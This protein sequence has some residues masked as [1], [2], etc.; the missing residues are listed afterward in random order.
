MSLAN[1]NKID[2]VFLLYILAL[3]SFGLIILTSASTPLGYDKFNDGYFFI[4]GQILNG[5]L[6]GL[7]LLYIFS[8]INYNF[9][10]KSVWLLVGFT[11]LLL[12]LVFIPGVGLYLNGARSWISFGFINFQPSELAKLTMVVLAAF[13][14]SDSRRDLSD[15]KT[16]LLPVLSVLAPI[17][18][19]VLAQPDLGTLSILV[20]IVFGMLYL[21]KVPKIYLTVL[22]SLLV[23][24]FLSLIVIKSYRMERF[25]TFLHP[26]LDPQGVGYHINQATLA[27]GSGGWAGLGVGHSR[28]KYQYLPEV[29][30][31][32]VF[33]V[34]A[35]EVGFL[36]SSL[37]LLLI[38]FIGW[39]GLRIAKKSPDLFAKLLVS[40]IMIWLVWQSFL[41]IGAMVGILPLTGVP[42]PFVSHGG[43]ALM[44]ML[45]A[46]GIVLSV[47]R[48]VNLK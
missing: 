36:F 42:L 31:D 38:L 26:E 34:M 6:P 3:L 35:E 17:F 27:I 14:F 7:L 41:N 12:I 37:F 48:E 4:K 23:L 25:T 39:R 43:S 9:W 16:G 32:S 20:V 46:C 28:Q 29:A 30:A 45:G 19:L 8:K 10:K 13:L 1:K 15:W 40:G 47:S 11:I 21:S 2:K 24:G 44:V 22:G 33:A 18:L 5:V